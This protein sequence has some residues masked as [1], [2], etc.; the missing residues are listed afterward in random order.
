MHNIY[1]LDLDDS[2]DCFGKEDLRKHK[3][4][5]RERGNRRE[6]KREREVSY[7][8]SSLFSL[9]FLWFVLECERFLLVWN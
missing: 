7:L 8:I 5:K 1:N 2:F 3:E 9:L 4:N 6:R